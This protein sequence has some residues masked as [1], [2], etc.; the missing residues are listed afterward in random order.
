MNEASCIGSGGSCG[1]KSKPFIIVPAAAVYSIIL[2]VMLIAVLYPAP[3]VSLLTLFAVNVVVPVPPL[4]TLRV[5]AS[6][7]AP[8]V[9]VDG[10]NPVVPAL[11]D[12]TDK[13]IDNSFQ[14]I[15]TRIDHFGVVQPKTP[16]TRH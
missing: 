15:R 13:A 14:V 2:S 3:S 4:A 11:K 5:P 12:E 16:K 7:T 1:A 8:V 10:V 9:A 6:V